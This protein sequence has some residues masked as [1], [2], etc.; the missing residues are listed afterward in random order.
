MPR[1]FGE[2]PE[3][4]PDPQVLK[5][6]KPPSMFAEYK[7]LSTIFLI[8]AVVLAFYFIKW[9]I[10]APPHAPPTPVRESVYIESVQPVPI[11]TAPA[12]DG[13]STEVQSP[14]PAPAAPGRN[15]PKSSN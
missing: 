1:D 3:L 9:M 12:G 14:A 10:T 4:R 11:E 7:V 15:R 5:Q 8:G 13:S 6:F 2:H